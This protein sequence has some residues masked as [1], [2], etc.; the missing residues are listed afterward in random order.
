M[1]VVNYDRQPLLGRKWMNQ[2]QTFNKL[3]ASLEEI[4]SLNFVEQSW[5]SRLNNLLEKYA[6]VTSEEFS[7]IK[8][9]K[10]QLN[11]KSN[12]QPVFL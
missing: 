3:K 9:I 4:Q 6:E 10:A 7:P 5:N 8:K 11:L 1:Y 2:L 12:S